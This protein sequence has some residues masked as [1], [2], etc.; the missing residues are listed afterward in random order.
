MPS[1][2][3]S[4]LIP[5]HDTE[6]RVFESG[7]ADGLLVLVLDPDGTGEL[8]SLASTYRMVV[9]ETRDHGKSD[10]ASWTPQQHASD[11][12]AVAA[13]LGQERYAVLGQGAGTAIARQ[14][15]ID[16]P[17]AAVATVLCGDGLDSLEAPQ[18]VL[19]C[20]GDAGEVAAFLS[21]LTT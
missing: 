15:A 18:P 14:H 3:P 11:V 2:A 16:A 5:V 8:T 7:P 12:S 10:A 13:A 20:T 1:D 9:V 21:T 4:R 19:V 17:G 6:L